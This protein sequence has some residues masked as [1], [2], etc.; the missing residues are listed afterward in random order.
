MPHSW[1][2]KSARSTLHRIRSKVKIRQNLKLEK[3]VF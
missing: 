2:E 3:N 1:D